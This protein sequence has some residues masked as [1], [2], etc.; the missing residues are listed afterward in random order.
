MASALIYRHATVAKKMRENT[1]L[2]DAKCNREKFG[3]LEAV[4]VVSKPDRLV[5]LAEF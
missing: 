4:L 2:G 3:P 1:L 5:T